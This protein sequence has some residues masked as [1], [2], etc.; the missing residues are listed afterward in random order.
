MK[1]T[2]PAKK[3]GEHKWNKMSFSSME[4][5]G[6]DVYRCAACGATGTRSALASTVTSDSNDICNPK[7]K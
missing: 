1:R 4:K 3:F 5:R 6:Y 7:V 2:K